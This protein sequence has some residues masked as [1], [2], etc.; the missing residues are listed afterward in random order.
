[1][2]QIRQVKQS[3]LLLIFLFCLFFTLVSYAIS[4]VQIS[5]NQ[6]L[7][8]TLS[9]PFI[10]TSPL[11][12]RL[13]LKDL[14]L[15]VD[16]SS[17]PM[18]LTL[19]LSHLELP[20]PYHTIRKLHLNCQDLSFDHQ[21]VSCKKGHI[22]FKGL[23]SPKKQSIPFS[24]TYDQ[25][26]SEL[27]LTLNHLKIG[28]GA[29]A[30]DV[31]LKEPFW[32]LN[33]TASQIN[34]MDIKPYLH[35][36]L[37]K[38]KPYNQALL[39]NSSGKINLTI[40]S[41]GIFST[42]KNIETWLQSAHIS[43][44]LKDLKYQYDD[45]M[46]ENVAAN[47]DF[48]ISQTAQKTR[49]P[50]EAPLPSKQFK[51]HIKINKIRGE[52][53]QNE[54]YI[55]PTAQE[56]FSAQ[57]TYNAQQETLLFSD[58]NLSSKKLFSLKGN[59]KIALNKAERI[60]KINMQ[61]QFMDLTIL[62]QLYVSN[63]LSDG[64][65][66]GLNLGGKISGQFYK[67]EDKIKV[68]V[69]FDQFSASDKEQKQFSLTGLTG[70]INWNNYLQKKRPVAKS[71]ISWQQLT[72]NTLPL[73]PVTLHFTTHHNTL[74][75]EQELDI[76]LFDGALH[77]HSLNIDPILSSDDKSFTLS[78]DGFIKP[79]SLGLLSRHFDWPLL[80]G[81]LSAVIPK[82]R[83]NEKHLKMGGAM[84]LDV[85]GGHIIIKDL[86]IID[87]LESYAQLFANIDFNNLDLKSLTKTY[88]FGE[89][90][91]RVEGKL[92]QLELNA[93]QPV[94]FDAYIR[95]PKKDK[96]R[97]KISQRAIDNLSS[98]GGAS[99]LLSRSFL[100]FFEHFRYD[101]LGLSCQLKN[102]ICQMSGIEKKGASYYIVKG[103]GIPR[104]DVMGFQK[105]VDWHVLIRRLKAIQQANEVIIE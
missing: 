41:S 34:M 98:L 30:L 4:T 51:A 85:F 49:L 50:L 33:I 103:G 86:S 9:E 102:K 55:V 80:D 13:K 2:L 93:W 19:D 92:A 22:T 100:R 21:K 77:I 53:F 91:G 10:K 25:L 95:T 31:H 75:L 79:I 37:F 60:Q 38:N 101:K 52:F 48:K 56:N 39:D 76:S 104:I 81:T 83:Y 57:L 105:Q 96:S 94:A 69:Y 12:K 24:L 32:Q 70:N 35:Y 16:I 89:I 61:F 87:P 63:I 27:Q 44:Q 84:M 40:K 88:D 43:A 14:K 6:L 67:N 23:G 17:S 68:N 36:Y 54:L 59:A 20:K 82:T 18:T 64:D 29:I 15:I 46:A 72:V 71:Q 5:F 73:N 42:Q 97:H 3:I 99:G 45:N 74:L 11:I 65:Y 26:S 7:V 90:Q 28:Q 78:I 66:D 47:F 8:N 58:I 62:N 1:M